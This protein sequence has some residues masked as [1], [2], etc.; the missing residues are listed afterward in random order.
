[1]FNHLII[2]QDLVH[3][4]P[5]VKQLTI[6][7]QECQ[8]AG[9][10]HSIAPEMVATRVAALALQGAGGGWP[11]LD[12]LSGFV[13]DFYVLAISC[14]VSRLF[15]QTYDPILHFA[16]VD[17]LSRTRPPRLSLGLYCHT[18]TP[19]DVNSDPARNML[20]YGDED[21]PDSNRGPGALATTHLPVRLT[22]LVVD[23]STRSQPAIF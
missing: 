2:L 17:V 4:F 16:F 7:M 3:L 20:V 23:A 21:V 12:V 15:L 6:L 13:D 9:V 8:H 14:P 1:M 18:Q 10:T 11:C 5:K 22:I 19:D